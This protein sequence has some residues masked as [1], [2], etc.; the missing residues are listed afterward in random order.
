MSIALQNEIEALKKRVEAL[1]EFRAEV[2]EHAQA[3]T[4][5]RLARTAAQRRETLTLEKR[6][7]A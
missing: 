4:E 7:S 1:E 5:G 2:I 6:K 3:Q